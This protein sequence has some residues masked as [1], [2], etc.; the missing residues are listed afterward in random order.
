MKLKYEQARSIRRKLTPP[1]Y[2]LWKRLKFRGNERPVFRRQ[3]AVGP[4]IA[5]FYCLKARLVVEV[6]GSTHC[7]D[8]QI[9]RD[10]AR[11]A[12]LKAQGIENYRVSAAEVF[13]SPDQAADGIILLALDRIGSL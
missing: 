2:L 8:E 9:A 3:E 10:A 7:E 12:W 4:Y 6:D 5:D 11:D 13:R 1:E